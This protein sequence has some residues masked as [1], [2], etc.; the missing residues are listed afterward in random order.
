MTVL[1]NLYPV[2]VVRASYMTD[3]ASDNDHCPCLRVVMVI[4]EVSVDTCLGLQ[5]GFEQRTLGGACLLQDVGGMESRGY[6]LRVDAVLNTLQ[7][8]FV[9]IVEDGAHLDVSATRRAE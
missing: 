6:F 5:P 8:L 2:T 4:L 3:I 7:I 1:V 9:V